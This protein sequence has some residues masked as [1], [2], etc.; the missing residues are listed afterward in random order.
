MAE[1]EYQQQIIRA[2]KTNNSLV[3]NK[4]YT[5]NFKKTEMFV[6]QNQGSSQQAKDIYQEAFLAM[7]K[8]IRAGHFTPE[9][10]TAIEGYLY[11]IA[12]NK[13]TDYLR[14]AAFKKNQPLPPHLT[15]THEPKTTLD[16]QEE[17]R[18][19][20]VTQQAFSQLG[21][22]CKQLL[23][24]F[25]FSK[26][27]LREIAKNLNISEASTRNKKYRCIQKLK[28]IAQAAL[29]NKS[30]WKPLITSPPKLGTE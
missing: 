23:T 22:A 16:F 7:W 1:I 26:K 18:Q 6:V 28:E 13:W 14:S 24:D 20:T 25:Y 21:N 8:N 17:D 12:K 30:F 29:K 2:I 4:L 3:L 9:N 5:D 15:L 19:T 11:Q 10:P 27:P